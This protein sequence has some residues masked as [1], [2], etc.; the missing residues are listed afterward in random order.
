[1]NKLRGLKDYMPRFASRDP[2]SNIAGTGGTSGA[3]GTVEPVKFT[4]G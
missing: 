2:G 1:M 3:M 4:S